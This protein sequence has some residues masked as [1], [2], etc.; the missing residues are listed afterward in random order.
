[1]EKRFSD[2]VLS[3]LPDDVTKL[4]DHSAGPWPSDWADNFG[5]WNFFYVAGLR[6]YL[7]ARPNPV[8]APLRAKKAFKNF[9]SA[10]GS[11][12]RNEWISQLYWDRDPQDIDIEE[13][14]KLL[15]LHSLS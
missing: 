10:A 1:M 5:M 6:E 14:K 7:Q 13:C 3:M 9:I 11:L 8:I 12:V 15:K 2:A 4:C